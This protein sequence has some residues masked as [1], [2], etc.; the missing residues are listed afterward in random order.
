MLQK[1]TKKHSVIWRMFTSVTLESAVFMGKNYSDNWHSIKNTR[2][3]T[4]KQ[5]V[6][7]ICK[8][9]VWARWDIWSGNTWLGESFME[10]FV[11]DWWWTSHQSSAHKGLRL[12][13]FC[14]VSG[15]RY[16][17]TLAQTQHGKT[18]WDGSKVHRNTETW[19]ELTA[20]QWNFEWIIFPGFNTLQ[21]S[22]E[23]KSLLLRSDETPEND[24]GRIIFNVDVQRHLMGIKR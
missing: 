18:D 1:K 4:L 14:I 3:L 24:T 16:T 19:T 11:F 13:R 10:V 8:I 9:G 17:R 20:S 12:F 22:Q 23:L 6:R 5:M 15:V 7:H 21:L 2:D